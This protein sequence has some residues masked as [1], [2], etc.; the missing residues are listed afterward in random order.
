M[1]KRPIIIAATILAAGIVAIAVGRRAPVGRA[2]GDGRKLEIAERPALT[3]EVM[4]RVMARA[5]Q[6]AE[7][8]V[9]SQRVELNSKG[10]RI[11]VSDLNVLEC[12]SGN[13]PN[14]MVLEQLGGEKDGVGLFVSGSTALAVGD[15]LIVATKAKGERFHLVE[16]DRGVLLD[17]KRASVAERQALERDLATS[18]Q[19]KRQDGAGLQ[20]V[21]DSA[22]DAGEPVDSG[23]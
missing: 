10:L 16:N 6:V 4:Q 1:S 13:C 17:L 20:R 15:S 7:I 14:Q 5:E 8:T 12:K 18:V 3:P 23:S 21:R 2:V 22:I 11:T 19:Q 9:A